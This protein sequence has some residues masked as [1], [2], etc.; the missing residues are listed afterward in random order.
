MKP[1]R[2]R[3]RN[4]LLAWS[5]Y[6]LALIAVG[7]SPAIGAIWRMSQ[8]PHGNGSVNAGFNGGVLSA[9]VL[10]NGIPTWTGSISVLGLTLLIALPPLVMWALFLFIAP[11]TINADESALSDRSSV[12]E[13]NAGQSDTES[14]RTSGST[15]K[16]RSREGF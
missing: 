9:N 3:V 7:L 1:R 15:L 6:W 16:R 10:Q 11:R 2:F 5:T 12:A 8:L 14:F 13:L 4:L